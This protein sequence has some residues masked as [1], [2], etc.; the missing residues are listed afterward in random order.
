MSDVDVV[1]QDGL[2]FY[3]YQGDVYIFNPLEEKNTGSEEDEVSSHDLDSE[4]SVKEKRQGKLTEVSSHETDDDSS[5]D[6]L[7]DGSNS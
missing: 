5:N 7:W 6:V 4:N 1:Q 2:E 3:S